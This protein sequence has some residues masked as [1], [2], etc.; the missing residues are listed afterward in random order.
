[1]RLKWSSKTN[2]LFKRAI[3]LA[4]MAN[5]MTSSSPLKLYIH[6]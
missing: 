3:P 5:K 4:M 6:L 2:N 1:M